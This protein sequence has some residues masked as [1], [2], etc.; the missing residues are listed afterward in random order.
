[1]IQFSHLYMILE[2]HS[3]E[4]ADLYQ[5][6]DV[7]AFLIHC[8]VR[9]VVAFLLDSLAPSLSAFRVV[10]S[11]YLRLLVFLLVVL[12][13]VCDSSTLAFHMM[14]SACKFNKQGDN[15]QPWHA[16]FPILNQ[17]IV[18]CLVLTLVSWSSCLVFGFEPLN[19]SRGWL[20]SGLGFMS[21]LRGAFPHDII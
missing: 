18:S 10:S 8:H 12:I 15:I 19:E 4:Y 14:Y 1:M 20:L 11:S 5:Q 6:N 13:P 2:N 21:P 9:F 7:S 3:F 16:P 17:S